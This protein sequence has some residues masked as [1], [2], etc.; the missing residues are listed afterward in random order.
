MFSGKKDPVGEMGKGVKKVVKSYKK[1]GI[2]DLT[3]HLYENGRH[4]MLHEVNK[5]E[6][7]KDILIW[8]NAHI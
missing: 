8:L 7:Q 1:R 4:E 2:E 3:V 5:K 6:V